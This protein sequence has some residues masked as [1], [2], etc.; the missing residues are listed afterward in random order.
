[1]ADGI[2]LENFDG[3]PRLKL[4]GTEIPSGVRFNDG[5]LDPRNRLWAGTIP[6]NEKEERPVSS[7]YCLEDPALKEIEK[8]L[9]ISN[10]LGWSPDQKILYHVDTKPKIVWRYDYDIET[11]SVK[12]RRVFLQIEDEGSPDGMCID[13]NGN[14][15]IAMFGGYKVLIFSASGLLQ[16]SIRLPVPN[17]T[18][19]ALNERKN[20]MFI[21]TARDGLSEK[22][23][24]N[25]PLSGCV[26]RCEF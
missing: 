19:C 12:N 9:Y 13:R 20:E 10:G 17:V 11:G 1:M 25:Y 21:T 18:S 3:G 7:L 2:Y 26:F 24:K 14:L 15:Y 16:D 4:E 8:D 5:K 22:E 6:L 23:Q